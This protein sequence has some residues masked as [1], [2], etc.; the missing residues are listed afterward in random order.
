[1]ISL[2]II[3]NGK[4]LYSSHYRPAIYIFIIELCD[5][6]RCQLTLFFISGKNSRPVLRADIVPLP[7]ELGRIVRQEES[8]QQAVIADHRWVIEDIHGFGMPCIP[9]AHL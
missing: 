3:E 2:R 1:M 4:R 9:T 8:S 5:I 6:L 7:V